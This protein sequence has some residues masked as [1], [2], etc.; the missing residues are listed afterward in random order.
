MKR[1]PT[2]VILA[3]AL[4]AA[5][6]HAQA[7]AEPAATPAPASQ[8]VAGTEDRPAAEGEKKRLSDT[9]CVR[10]TGSRIAR[11]DGTSRCTGQPGRSY[12]KEDLDRTGHTNIGDALR[13]LDP[14]VY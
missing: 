4:F 2:F 8:S 10:E 11:R 6:A 3:A 7:P 5:T 13:A 12:T 9:N 1:M 14:A